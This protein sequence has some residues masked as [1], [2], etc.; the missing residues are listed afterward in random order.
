MLE[1]ESTDVSPEKHYEFNLERPAIWFTWV[2]IAFAFDILSLAAISFG[3]KL[4]AMD[5]TT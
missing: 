1:T 3:A 4:S 5:T 2:K